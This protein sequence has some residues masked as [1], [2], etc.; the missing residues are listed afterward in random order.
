MAAEFNSKQP[1]GYCGCKSALVS[2]RTYMIENEEAR[3]INAG[4]FNSL[5]FDIV[6]IELAKLN[7]AKEGQTL[8]L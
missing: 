6:T 3:Q 1:I 2:Y 8:A 4:T 5:D 7:D